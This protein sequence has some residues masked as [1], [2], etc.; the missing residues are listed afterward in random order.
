MIFVKLML[1]SEDGV[2]VLTSCKPIAKQIIRAQ[3]FFPSPKGL[4]ELCQMF[5]WISNFQI[6]FNDVDDHRFTGSEIERA[7]TLVALTLVALT[8]VAVHTN[9]IKGNSFYGEGKTS[10][11]SGTLDQYIT[12]DILI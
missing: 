6:V 8:M 7:L 12:E 11:H 1:G 3:S 10:I 9:T 5:G 4:P 2:Q